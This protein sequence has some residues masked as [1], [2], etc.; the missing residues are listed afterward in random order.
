MDRDKVI[1]SVVASVVTALLFF[2]GSTIFG[3]MKVQVDRTQI[4]AIASAFIDE[5]NNL[6]ALLSAME[7]HGGFKGSQGVQGVQGNDGDQG[8]IGPPWNPTWGSFELRASSN[9]PAN[10]EIEIGER[11]IC[12]LTSVRT[13]HHEQACGCVLQNTANGWLMKLTLDPD[14]AGGCYCASTCFD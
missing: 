3:V 4:P 12:A 10:Q 11:R 14:V 1:T 2:V 9:N 7:E 5:E 6:K 13:L 8:D